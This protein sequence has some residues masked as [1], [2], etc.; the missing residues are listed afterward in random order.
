MSNAENIQEQQINKNNDVSLKQDILFLLLKI[1]FIFLVLFIIFTFIYGIFRNGYAN[2]EP[3]INSGDLV[4]YYRLDKNY[5]SQDIA[6]IN[7]ENHTYALRVVAVEGDTVDI[8]ENGLMINGSLQQEDK[9]YETTQR[10]EEGI[11]FPVT[12]QEDEIFVLGD[13]RENATD[14]R[15]FGPIKTNETLGKVIMI[16][17]RRGI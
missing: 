7:Y 6:V 13:S 16:L 3:A 17:R 1:G 12:L 9:I 4:V 5:V 11:D 10:Y 14:S 15:I 8:S 2:M